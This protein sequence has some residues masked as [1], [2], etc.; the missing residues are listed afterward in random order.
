LQQSPL[1]SS[2]GLTFGKALE[3]AKDHKS[4]DWQLHYHHIVR[5]RISVLEA[6]LRIMPPDKPE[7]TSQLIRDIKRFFAEAG[8]MLDIK[9]NPPLIVP[10]EEPLLQKET[11]DKLLPRLESQFPERAQELVRVYHKLLEG[12]DLDGVF[13][14]AFKTLEEI[15]RTLTKYKSFKFN[16][17]KDLKKYFPDLHST[18]H[19]T[20]IRLAGHRGDEGAHGRSAP[21]PHE[22]RY[23]LFSI[24]NVALLLLD[25][26]KSEAS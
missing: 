22:I 4:K 15:A 20:I 2:R 26:P 5:E 7:T 10:M 13:I 3:A 14:E 25:Y 9:G 1:K 21:D 16:S 23:L 19:E 17:S 18:I 12:K 11:I 8:I 24:C 6:L